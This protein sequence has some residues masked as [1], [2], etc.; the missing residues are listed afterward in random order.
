MVINDLE[1]DHSLRPP[2]HRWRRGSDIHGVLV[3]HSYFW[4]FLDNRLNGLLPG[5]S[6]TYTDYL[7]TVR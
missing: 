5:P 4:F 2:R 3:R 1:L 6:V 7:D